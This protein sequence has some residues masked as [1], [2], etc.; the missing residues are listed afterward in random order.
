MTTRKI[1]ISHRHADKK[2]ADALREVLNEW[3]LHHVFQSSMPE[4]GISPGKGLTDELKKE[5]SGTD[6][7]I[8]IFTQVDEDWSY[9]MWECGVATDP[10]NARTKVIVFQCT[11]QTPSVY[12]GQVRVKVT[13]DYVDDIR[14]FTK[15]LHLDE[16]FFPSKVEDGEISKPFDS[17]IDE[18]TLEK[19]TQRLFEELSA[20]IPKGRRAENYRWDHLNVRLP[21]EISRQIKEEP[22]KLMRPVILESAEILESSSGGA[23]KQFGYYQYAGTLTLSRVVDR[24]KDE[25][26]DKTS[27]TTWANEL[28]REIWNT[29][30]GYP[31]V[32]SVDAI[33]HLNKDTRRW[34]RPI[35]AVVRILPDD[36]IEL[37]VLLCEVGRPAKRR[38]TKKKTKKKRQATKAQTRRN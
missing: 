5:L 11:D 23:L 31:P 30:N 7:L 29:L 32:P 36:A 4:L 14:G 38:V 8:L 21:P 25:R 26:E 1:F 20:V 13:P 27:S 33:R 35:V 24:W 12:E 3:G 2:I 17:H 19:R 16:D 37:D 28:C 9:C 6:L 22:Y 15:H 34:Y 18:K 10:E